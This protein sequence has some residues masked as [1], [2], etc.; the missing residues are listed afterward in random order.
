MARNYSHTQKCDI[1]LTREEYDLILQRRTMKRWADE[2]QRKRLW[3]EMLAR[4]SVPK[5]G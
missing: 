3:R 4:Y 1:I 2:I 5:M